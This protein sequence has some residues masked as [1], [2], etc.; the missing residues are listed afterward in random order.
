MDSPINLILGMLI[1]GILA[2][3]VI[4]G[5][6]TNT[7]IYIYYNKQKKNRKIIIKAGTVN[8]SDDNR[9]H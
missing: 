1:V 9:K 2:H 8:R 7:K 4:I 3:T 5:Q 6:D